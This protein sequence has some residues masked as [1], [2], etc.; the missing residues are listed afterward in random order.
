MGAASG[1]AGEDTGSGW[2]AVRGQGLADGPPGAA[3]HYVLQAV[4]AFPAAVCGFDITN[5]GATLAAWITGK[6]PTV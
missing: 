2:T 1:R 6:M 3:N 4:V 5:Q